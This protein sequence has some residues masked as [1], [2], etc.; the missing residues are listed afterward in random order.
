MGRGMRANFII[1]MLNIHKIRRWVLRFQRHM[2]G[3]VGGGERGQ[4]LL[5]FFVGVVNVW[6]FIL[7]TLNFNISM[8]S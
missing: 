5:S 8:D 6:S 7:M 1:W 3:E 2:K 4:Y